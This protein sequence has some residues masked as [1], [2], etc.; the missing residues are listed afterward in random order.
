MGSG[1]A[2][3]TS[4]KRCRHCRLAHQL[5]ALG[6]AAQTLI[7]F[8]VSG[9][10]CEPSRAAPLCQKV[11]YRLFRRLARLFIPATLVA[12]ISW[13]RRSAG[14]LTHQE[15]VVLG[16]AL[17]GSEIRRRLARQSVFPYLTN[18]L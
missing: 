3:S 16:A 7:R 13:N 1:L 10:G 17:N 15:P 11:T 8:A 12:D 5:P 14:G 18:R 4:L 6:V 9:A 2:L